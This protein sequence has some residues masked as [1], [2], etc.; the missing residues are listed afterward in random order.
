MANTTFTVV[1]GTRASISTKDL[2]E[3]TTR[4]RI[5]IIIGT[6]IIIFTNYFRVGTSIYSIAFGIQARGRFAMNGIVN[7]SLFTVTIFS[8]TSIFIITFNRNIRTLAVGLQTRINCASIGIITVSWDKITFSSAF[9]TRIIST[10]ISIGT[11]SRSKDTTI[12]ITARVISAEIL[13]IAC[14][15]NVYTSSIRSATISSTFT[16][17]V[18]GNFTVNTSF[19][20]ITSVICTVILIIA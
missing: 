13:I 16:E 17:V 7:A 2:R 10:K 6:R 9:I 11:N 15:L 3:N 5:T 12:N 8:G 1:I 19:L 4:I 14:Y 18:T 20:T